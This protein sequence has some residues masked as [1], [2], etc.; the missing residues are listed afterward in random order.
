[1]PGEVVLEVSPLPGLP[2]IRASGE[3]SAVT[4]SSWEA[5]LAELTRRHTDV[6]YVELS[7]VVF[8]D[9]AGVTALATTAMKLPTGRV[10]VQHPPPQLPRLLEMFWP[11]LQRVEVAPR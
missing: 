7:E 6:S 8:V 9:V 4:R 11:N 2:G 5:A 1:M 10:V 3:I